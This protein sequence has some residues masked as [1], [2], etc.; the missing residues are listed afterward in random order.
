MSKLS[1]FGHQSV[2]EL[3]NDVFAPCANGHFP[4]EAC[5]FLSISNL[6]IQ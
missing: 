3:A 2:F 5:D 4:A 6:Q 1:E